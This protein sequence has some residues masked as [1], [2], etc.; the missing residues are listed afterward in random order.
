MLLSNTTTQVIYMRA[1]W[2]YHPAYV[3]PHTEV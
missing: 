1:G 3:T 2:D